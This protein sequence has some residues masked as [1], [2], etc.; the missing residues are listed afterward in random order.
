MGVSRLLTC[1]CCVRAKDQSWR[2]HLG[3]EVETPYLGWWSR[4]PNF[5][6]DLGKDFI[7][8]S[9]SSSSETVVQA[10]GPQVVEHV[11]QAT[12]FYGHIKS[13]LVHSCQVGQ[14]VTCCKTQL[15]AN[16]KKLARKI[17]VVHPKCI[18]CFPK[19]NNRIGSLEQMTDSLDALLKKSRTSRSKDP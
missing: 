13:G 1:L 12:E 7:T 2:L 14:D 4:F 10:H 17:H 8:D 15:G 11:P 3:V 5:G 18:C 6:F 19:N 9:G 16:F